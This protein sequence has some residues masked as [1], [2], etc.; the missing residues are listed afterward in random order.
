MFLLQMGLAQREV[1]VLKQRTSD[2]MEAKMRVGGWAQKAPDGYLNKERLVSSNKY[3]RWVELI[4][5]SARF[6]V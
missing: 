1:D 5:Y 6:F 2:G 4:R 3:E